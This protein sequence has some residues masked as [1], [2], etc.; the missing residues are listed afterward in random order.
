MKRAPL[1]GLAP[2]GLFLAGLCLTAIC[3]GSLVPGVASGLAAQT[4]RELRSGEAMAAR[5]EAAESGEVE[6]PT[7][8]AELT[9][10]DVDA[11]LAKVRDYLQAHP[12]DPGAR[13]LSVRLGRIRDV[14]AFRD[15]FMAIFQDPGA[16]APEPPS[17]TGHL[18]VLDEVLAEHPARADAH[19]WRARL[20]LEETARDAGSAARPALFPLDPGGSAGG[21]ILL[22]ARAAV[23]HAPGSVRYRE[24]LA[25]LFAMQGDP[26]GSAAVLSHRATAGGLM[27]LLAEDAVAFRPPPPAEV[28]AVV[29][30]FAQMMGLMGAGGTGEV[31]M[32]RY[33]ELRGQG[34]STPLGAAEVESDYRVRLPGIRFQDA[35]GFEGARSAGFILDRGVWRAALSDEEQER[36]EAV[37]G[38]FLVL[39]LLPAEAYEELCQGL[40]AHGIPESLVLP[41]PRTGILY[42]NGRRGG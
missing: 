41:G 9:V 15:A 20:T 3:T 39:L 25:L 4:P 30:Q 11:E 1:A 26:A 22:H 31:E 23:E 12:G 36:V 19:Y 21:R 5:V 8:D 34:W 42:M 10:T 24:F 35:E 27:H 29:L 13:V 14:L 7:L 17:L 16:G 32:G 33:M 40:R 2:A 6:D 38:S 37:G 18:R 28:D